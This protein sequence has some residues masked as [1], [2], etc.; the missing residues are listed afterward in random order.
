MLRVLA[1]WP[2]L[3]ATAVSAQQRPLD[4]LLLNGQ[5]LDGAGNPW[6]R[7]DVGI[8]GDRIEFVGSARDARV[9][10]RDTID[11][12]GLLVTPGFV[13]MHSHAELE[14]P[15]GKAALTFLYQGITTVVIG[16]DGG[17]GANV[18]ETFEGY[19]RSGMGVNALTYVGQGAARGAAIGAADRPPTPQEM[20]TMK[21]FIRRGM[22]EGALGMSTGLFYVPG[23]YARTDEVVELNRVAAEYGGIYDTHDRDLGAAYRSIGFPASMREAIEIGER[24]GTPVIFSHLNPQGR[25]NYGKA[26]EAARII[27]QARARGVNVMAA[28]HPYTATQSSLSAYTI[29]RWASVGGQTA[30]RRRFEHPDTARMLDVQTM[31]MLDI[32]G[33]P[34]KIR[35]VDRRPELNGKTLAQ[36]AQELGLP[37][38]AAVR[39]VLAGGNASVMNLDLYDLENTKELAKQDWMMTCTDGRTPPPGADIVHP[40]PYG[41]FTR[42]L[43]LFALE[44]SVITLP[45]AVRGMTSLAWTFL[46]IA[47]RGLIR[48]GFYADIAVLD[49]PR[50]R[51]RATYEQPHQYS[52]GT[53]HV[54]VNGRFA[55]RDGKPTTALAGRPILRGGRAL[56]TR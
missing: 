26:D 12:S 34:E 42:K 6:V 19:L 18:R 35:F 8:T 9:A 3:F 41:A 14:T 5:V 49:V 24:A 29:P 54:L 38:P 32:R 13:D 22:E 39:R 43:R 16:V 4:V 28:H 7:Q 44:D 23:Y 46:G 2:L 11:V 56:E 15:H 20:A 33:G 48:P 27:N 1:F 31:E 30:M 25:H 37:V 36:V 45:F 47:D 17:G 40:R 51:D 55:F 52:E 53:V 21:A 10:A 50:I